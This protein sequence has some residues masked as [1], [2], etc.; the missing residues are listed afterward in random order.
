MSSIYE[1]SIN[2]INIHLQNKEYN[3]VITKG[4]KLFMD[5][6][7][8]SDF[9]NNLINTYKTIND[10]EKTINWLKSLIQV[11]PSNLIPPQYIPSYC[12]LHNELTIM[13]TTCNKYTEAID[14]L[15]KINSVK[16]DIPDI[17]NNLSICHIS[18]KEYHKAIICL[19]I[20]LNLA[21][22]DSTYR[23]L[24]NVHFY[25][26]KYKESINY[27]ESIKQPNNNDLYNKSF[28]YLA[29]KQY[30]NGFKLYENRLANNEIHPQTNQISRVEIPS[31]PYWDGKTSCNHLMIIYEQGIGD[32]IQY[33]RFI[34]ELA[35]RYPKLK[36]T[37]FC[38]SI[39]SHLFNVDSYDNITI[40]DDSASINITIYDKKLYIMSLPYI[41]K[42][43]TITKNPNNY[44]ICN[45]K[46]DE[47]WFNK[48]LPFNNKLKVGIMYSGLLISYLDKQIEL[49]HFKPICCDDNIQTI[50]L[51]KMDDKIR[52][53]FSKI[54]FTSEIYADEIDTDKA[55]MDTISILRNIDILVTIDTSIAHLAG[56]MGVKTLLLIGYTSEWRWFDNDDKV[57]YDSVDIIRM[58]EQKPLADLIPRVKN[59]LDAEY[60]AKQNKLPNV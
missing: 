35:K 2:I 24:A 8:R 60:L 11:L 57:W 18:L 30:L 39:I 37:Y 49:K 15:K 55:F 59:I 51:H 5:Y 31:L 45:E 12:I 44:I 42:L 54:D 53:D 50:C 22:T 26:K 17:Y 4:T 27:Y 28:P 32:N 48:M 13:Y 9:L 33:F 43:E 20:S 3:D 14:C 52:G 19:K 6:P 56:V 21:K 47:I 38:K 36:I 41:L 40:I 34:I 10:T 1:N 29:T 46:N 58:T 16:N 23:N 7:E 25:I